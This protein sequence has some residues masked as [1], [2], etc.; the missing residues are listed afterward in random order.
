MTAASGAR[1]L[2]TSASNDG[3]LARESALD[4]PGW[5]V[6]LAAHFGVMVSFGSLLVFT[7]G[8]FLKPLGAE[9]GWSREEISRAFAIGAMTVAVASPFLGRLLDR[10]GARRIVLPCM[11]VFGIAFSSLALLTP[12][13]WHL[14]AT[15]VVLGIVGNGT[16]QLGYSGAITSWFTARRGLALAVVMAGVGMGSIVLP[17]I[18]ERV[19]ELAG[20]RAAYAVL[21]A[22][23]FLLGLPLSLRFLRNREQPAATATAAGDAGATMREALRSRVFWIIV[24]TLFLASIS[25]NGALT[26][27]AAMLTDRGV[28]AG[29]AALA[30]AALGAASLTGRLLTGWMLDRFHGPRIAMMLLAL[31][32]GGVVLLSQAHTLTAG[33]VAAVFIGLGMGGEA[34]VTPY[35]LSR[36]FGLRSLSALYGLTWTF[37]AVAG[38]V[39]PILMGRAFDLTGSYARLMLV[40]AVPMLLS[41]LLFLWMPRYPVRWPGC[42][43]NPDL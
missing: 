27:M 19:I 33:I 16:T 28:S 4:Y 22:L 17:V 32:T 35:L 10:Y 31:M 40:L 7:F 14:Y 24:V 25:S 13:L 30:A 34:D 42:R 37:Y 3:A 20:W 23:I 41:T 15:F 43:G 29:G 18:A 5:R 11:L 26:H 21:G 8:I 12:N 39:G 2:A 38:G 1:P 36:Y 9:F 6:V